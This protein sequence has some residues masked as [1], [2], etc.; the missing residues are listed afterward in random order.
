MNA[1][2]FRDYLLYLHSLGTILMFF[3]HLFLIHFY[4]FVFVLI[5]CLFVISQFIVETDLQAGA[6]HG[7]EVKQ[8]HFCGFETDLQA[9]KKFL[10]LL[11]N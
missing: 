5:D 7:Y 2:C 1:I 10:L 3:F 9:V 6:N 11:T 8:S 4:V